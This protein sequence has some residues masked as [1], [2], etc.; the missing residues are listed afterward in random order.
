MKHQLLPLVLTMALAA[1]WAHLAAQPVG[2][3]SVTVVAFTPE[4]RARLSAQDGATI[5][6][7]LS[8]QLVEGGQYRVLRRTWLPVEKGKRP[9]LDALRSAAATAGV[10]Y[11]VIGTVG[12]IRSRHSRSSPAPGVY[13]PQRAI[14]ATLPL[15]GVWLPQGRGMRLTPSPPVAQWRR[16]RRP[17]AERMVRI[18]VDV[19]E[20]ASGQTVDRIYAERPMSLPGPGAAALI[21]AVVGGPAGAAMMTAAV[22]HRRAA[23]DGEKLNKGVRAAIEGIAHAMS[24]SAGR[25]QTT[26]SERHPS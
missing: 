4:R 16:P 9:S 10:E 17:L 19:I 24:M 2:K 7:E 11:L 23:T 12:E 5:A 18:S 20:V 8:R 6:D 14:A 1:D 3:P 22:A 21:G 26:D 25:P 13:L 15:R